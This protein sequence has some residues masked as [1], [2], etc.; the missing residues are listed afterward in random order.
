MKYFWNRSPVTNL[1]IVKKYC[2]KLQWNKNKACN[3]LL[4]DMY[5][6][7][8]SMLFHPIYWTHL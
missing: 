2:E 1:D 3:E 8:D 7:F 4:I 5:F 6:K